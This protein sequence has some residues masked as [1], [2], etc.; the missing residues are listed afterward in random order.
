MIRIFPSLFFAYVVFFV[1]LIYIPNSYS[2]YINS[3]FYYKIQNNCTNEILNLELVQSVNNY[4]LTI[5][6]ENNSDAQLWN[7]IPEE[8]GNFRFSNKKLGDEIALEITE[9]NGQYDIQ[10]DKMRGSEAQ[11]WQ[12]STTDFIY[13]KITPRLMLHDKYLEYEKGKTSYK[14]TLED[15]GNYCEQDWILT[16]T[17]NLVPGG[18][19][20]T[21]QIPDLDPKRNVYE[22]MGPTNKTKYPKTNGYIKA[23]MLFVDFPDAPARTELTKEVADNILNKGKAQESIKLQS[24]DEL[25]LDIDILHGWKRMKN[26]S[27]KYACIGTQYSFCDDTDDQKTYIEDVLDLFKTTNF[28]IYDMVFIVA[29]PDTQLPISPAFATLQDNGI[30]TAR[31]DVK[32]VI[33]FGQDSYINSQGRLLIHEF[34]HLLGLLDLYPNPED[35]TLRNTVDRWAIMSD[36][37]NATGF[38][39]WNRHKSGWMPDSTKHYLT[40]GRQ[41]IRLSPLAAYSGIHMVVVPIDDKVHPSRVYV[42]EVAQP[43]IGRENVWYTEGVLIYSVDAEVTSQNN[44]VV[45]MPSSTDESAIYGPLYKAPYGVGDIFLDK[46]NIMRMEVLKKIGSSYIIEITVP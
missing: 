2:E 39:G 36:Y 13:Y 20:K 16:Q 7:I 11:Y 23:L 14:I 24:Y 25:S 32:L 44:P 26:A 19:A 41:K 35:E 10:A 1:F 9:K 21:Q 8:D 22:T 6:E 37:E 17:K 28:S 12:L 29:S 38:I 33:T 42:I 30:S 27:T 3:N 18:I 4:K 46:E 5:A 45:I 43:I 15:S 34:G 31:G 40:S